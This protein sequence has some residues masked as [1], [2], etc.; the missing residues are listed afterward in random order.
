MLSRS[1]EIVSAAIE[2]YRMQLEVRPHL[3]EF[4]TLGRRGREVV[5]AQSV[6]SGS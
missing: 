5:A 4:M 1:G 3:A 6:S 2:V